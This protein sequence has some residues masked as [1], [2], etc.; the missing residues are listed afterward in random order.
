MKAIS[1]RKII[2][3]LSKINHWEGVTEFKCEMEVFE[4]LSWSRDARF[5][6]FWAHF[7]AVKKWRSDHAQ[8]V[9]LSCRLPQEKYA[10]IPALETPNILSKIGLC[11]ASTS[12]HVAL[13]NR[14][15][16]A[17]YVKDDLQVA[18]DAPGH[19]AAERECN[20]MERDD[21]RVHWIELPLDEYISADKSSLFYLLTFFLIGVYGVQKRTF[22]L[23]DEEEQTRS[24][25]MNA[26]NLYGSSAER[27]LAM[28]TLID[29][30]FEQE[31]AKKRPPLWP[32]I[33][34]K[35]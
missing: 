29:M 33:P 15:C 35:F 32:N 30:R 12:H 31:Y 3:E 27:I 11:L 34:L 1:M 5:S 25:R 13:P 24:R 26:R 16:G 9:S 19:S 14:D 6:S 20:L 10:E 22:S 18:K 28:E 7:K 21:K 4:N 2:I 23:P 8:M 17:A